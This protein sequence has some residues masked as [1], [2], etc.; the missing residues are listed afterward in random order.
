MKKCHILYF[1]MHPII[2]AK[3]MFALFVHNKNVLM[4]RNTIHTFIS[5]FD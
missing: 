3:Q 1:L 2:I 4:G 5:F